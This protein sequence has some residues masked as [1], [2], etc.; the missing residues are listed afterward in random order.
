[1]LASSP[2][3]RSTS[4]AA[5]TITEFCSLKDEWAC[6]LAFTGRSAGGRPTAAATPKPD[7]TIPPETGSA[8]SQPDRSGNSRLWDRERSRTRSGRAEELHRRTITSA[9]ASPPQLRSNAFPLGSNGAWPLSGYF[10]HRFLIQFVCTRC[11]LLK[12]HHER[13]TNSCE[14]AQPL[15]SMPTRSST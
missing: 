11:N 13:V 4:M 3:R 15:A 6:S 10:C 7:W 5:H 2:D 1:M 9:F 12:E 14:P 8:G